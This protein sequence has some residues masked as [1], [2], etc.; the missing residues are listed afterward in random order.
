MNS[1]EESAMPMVSSSN[2]RSCKY[3]AS[4]RWIPPGVEVHRGS[5]SEDIH[6]EEEKV[7]VKVQEEEVED[8]ETHGR[9]P[10][11]DRRERTHNH[12]G[13]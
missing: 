6:M 10:I 9:E 4:C 8:R 5:C 1:G 11:Q 7:E 12:S 13:A 3:E 2:S